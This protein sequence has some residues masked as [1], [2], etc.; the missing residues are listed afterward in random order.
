MIRAG[1]V[2]LFASLMLSCAGMPGPAWPRV[3]SQEQQEYSQALAAVGVDRAGGIRALRA[4]VF[5]HPRSHL[6]DDA[7]MRLAE[8]ALEDGRE[9]DALQHLSWVIRR[10]PKGDRSDRAR[11]EFAGLQRVRG[12]PKPAYRTA[13]QIRLSMLT[14][15]ERREAHRLLADLAGESGEAPAQLRWLSRVRADQADEQAAARVDT[16]IDQLI[17]TMDPDQLESAADQLGKRIP[18][19]QVRLRQAE[20]AL[21]AGDL[22]AAEVAVGRAS[23]LPLTKADASRLASYELVLGKSEKP[24]A[25]LLSGLPGIDDLRVERPPDPATTS[26]TLGVVLPLSG[27]FATY[28][29]ESLQGILLAAGM[30]DVS[31]P[32]AESRV[33]VLVRDSGGSAE[34][35]ARGV[36][37]LADESD[38]L[39][40]VG[41]LLGEESE[42][43]AEAADD[44]GVPLLAL[45]RRA[46]VAR[47]RPGVIRLGSSPLLEA[48]FLAD[49]AL[50]ELGIR[51][52]AILYP[53]DGYGFALR[54]AFWDAVEAQGGSVV[55]V[56]AYDPEAT[57]F[58]KP[59]RRIIGYELLS[60]GENGALARRRNLL[61]RAKRMP[62]ERAAELREEAAKITGPGGRPLPPFV[63]FDALFIPDSHENA[64]LIAPH[65]A[66]HE[67][68][69]VRL[70]GPSAWNHPDLV[71]IGGKHL[72]G[73]IFTG[74]FHPQSSYPF[75][76]EFVRRFRETFG[77]EPSSLAAQAFDAANLFLVQLARGHHSRKKVAEGL[78]ATRAY[79]GVSGVTTVRPDGNAAKRPYLLGVSRGRIVSVDETGEPPFL[80]FSRKK[81]PTDL[82]AGAQEQP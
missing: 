55:G 44:E 17:A 72:N 6:A 48:E 58:A 35:A 5:H 41:P 21:R 50:R 79:P 54:G 2:A 34:A 13:S 45:T 64:A 33:R 25:G 71:R 56:A 38:L 69:G 12:H 81:P 60:A 15:E 62:A 77:G 36:R 51:R 47:R 74:D 23:M 37:S 28:G 8:L 31:A 42:A 32:G 39:A 75:V 67:V 24:E 82:D 70:L 43:A 4:F 29:E 46:E 20:L 66:F 22:P 11:L 10:H 73:A 3:S 1:L 14:G 80:R 78:L 63:D 49:Y 27:P 40:I 52:F 16:E 7:S 59:I 57:D 30:F 26:G 65:L 61:K 19:A 18:A 9:T 53:R 68:R 76:A